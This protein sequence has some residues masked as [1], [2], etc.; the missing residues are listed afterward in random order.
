MDSWIIVVL[1]IV[2]LV[3]VIGLSIVVWAIRC[4]NWFRQTKVKIDESKSSIDVALTKRYDLLTKSLAT[5]KGYAKH[6]SETLIKI[7][8][9]RNPQGVSAM[10]MQEKSDFAAQLSKASKELNVVLE[11]YPELKADTQFTILQNQISDSEENLQASRRIFNSNISIY[12]QR[13]V[14][15]PS[16]IIANNRGYTKEVFFE[17]EIEKRQDVKMDF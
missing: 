10:N 1:V 3:V 15:W 17:A 8:Q 13:V 16:S 12:N 9:M 5:V 2:G 4:G 7:I 11:N 14:S 6:E